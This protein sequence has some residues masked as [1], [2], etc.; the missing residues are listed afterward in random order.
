M[1]VAAT[2]RGG[3]VA[4]KQSETSGGKDYSSSNGDGENQNRPHNKSCTV[5]DDK[6]GTDTVRPHLEPLAVPFQEALPVGAPDA[7]LYDQDNGD[8]EDT[9]QANPGVETAADKEDSFNPTPLLERVAWPIEDAVRPGA[10]HVSRSGPSD[11]TT[12]TDADHVDPQHSA[13]TTVSNEQEDRP[14]SVQTNIVSAYRVAEEEPVI[15][16]RYPSKTIKCT[17]SSM[18]SW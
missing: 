17:F 7:G 11:T 15:I 13:G 10:Y 9:T 18:D 5:V 6:R 14:Q 16:L 12:T 3:N 1:I 2:I 8:L 4:T